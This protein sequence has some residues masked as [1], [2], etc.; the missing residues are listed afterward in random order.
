MAHP[1]TRQAASSGPR[2]VAMASILRIP[3][4]TNYDLTVVSA[5]ITGVWTHYIDQHRTY[6]CLGPS[7]T[8]YFDHEATSLRWQGWLQVVTGP[9]RAS[10][11]LCVSEAAGRDTP[12]FWVQAGKLAGRQ[13]IVARAGH[14]IRGR[15]HT[16]L[17]FPRPDMQLPASVDMKRWLIGMWEAPSLWPLG[18]DGTS[19][20]CPLTTSDVCWDDDPHEFAKARP[21]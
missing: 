15:L 13:L 8:C 2:K 17:G 14:S 19:R 12:Q 3:P 5:S 11:F 9:G 16:M 6:P 18:K 7:A 20:L 4:G 21:A 10:R 1:D